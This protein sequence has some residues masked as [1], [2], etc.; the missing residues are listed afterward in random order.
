M[1]AVQALNWVVFASNFLLFDSYMLVIL[2]CKINGSFKHFIIMNNSKYQ[3]LKC[4][5]F[6]INSN[7]FRLKGVLWTFIIRSLII[8]FDVAT[9]LMFVKIVPRFGWFDGLIRCLVAKETLMG[10]YVVSL[11]MCFFWNHIVP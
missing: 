6:F 4:K 10:V 3:Y 9:F 11:I 8:H 2:D 1:V 7:C 5:V